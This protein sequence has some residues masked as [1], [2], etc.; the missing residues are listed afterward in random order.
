[1]RANEKRDCMRVGPGLNLELG[2]DGELLQ[3]LAGCDEDLGLGHHALVGS[4][5]VEV[6]APAVKNRVTLKCEL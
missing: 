5:H 2:C 6:L 1:M 3:D 4:H